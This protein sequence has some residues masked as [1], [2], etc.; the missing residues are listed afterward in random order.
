MKRK[1]YIFLVIIIFLAGSA[2][3]VDSL[4]VTSYSAVLMNSGNKKV[5]YAKNPHSKLAPASTAK[6]MTAIVVAKSSNMNKRIVVS[7]HAANEQPSKINIRPG[8][9]YYTRDLLKALL[10][11]SANDASVALAENIAGS[12]ERFVRMMNSASKRIG[13]KNTNFR[14]SNGLPAKCQYSTAYDMAIIMREASK[15]PVIMDIMKMKKA[16]IRELR[17]NR[18]ISL[19]NHNKSLWKENSYLI[20]GKTGWTIKA[21]HCFAGCIN[22]KNKK[23]IVVLLKSRK[24]WLDLDRLARK[25]K[26]VR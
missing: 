23:V 12:E 15:Y 1:R 20:L 11:N 21:R 24:L 7:R 19:R 17:T 9:V 10:L 5:L 18:K 3:A 6:I 13:A 14:T 16:Q 2:F 4:Y 22:Y 25:A 8:E 26:S